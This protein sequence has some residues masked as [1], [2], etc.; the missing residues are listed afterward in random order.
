MKKFFSMLLV[1]ALLASLSAC[2]NQAVVSSKD[3]GTKSGVTDF[4]SDITSDD[5]ADTET[6]DSPEFTESDAI[7]IAQD[8]VLV[9]ASIQMD[10]FHQVRELKYTDSQVTDITQEGGIELYEVTLKG[11]VL[12]Y[13][14]DYNTELETWCFTVVVTIGNDGKQHSGID[15]TGFWK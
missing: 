1:M 4:N 3:E 6:P 13:T 2:G 14:D 12:G 9:R 15:S 11:T 5:A 8:S 10:R 7:S